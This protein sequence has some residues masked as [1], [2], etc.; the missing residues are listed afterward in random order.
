MG[1]GEGGGVFWVGRKKTTC[2]QQRG[3]CLL[4]HMRVFSSFP[5]VGW[6]GVGGGGVGGVGEAMGREGG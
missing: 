1:G 6:G 4:C 2:V 5:R 3:S